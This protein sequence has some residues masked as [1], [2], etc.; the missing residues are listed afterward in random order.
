[1]LF[2]LLIGFAAA[3]LLKAASLFKKLGDGRMQVVSICLVV[4]MVGSLGVQMFQSQQ[5]EKV[6]WL[7]L[8][9]GPALLTIARSE[10]RERGL[11]PAPRR[12]RASRRP[13]PAY[14][15]S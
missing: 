10:A 3:S 8:G 14:S 12:A 4:A 1:V 6:I 9:L 13:V 15:P 2:V 11:L 5:Q 7:L